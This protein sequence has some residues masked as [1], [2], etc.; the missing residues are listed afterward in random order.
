MFD[1]IVQENEHSFLDSDPS[2]F[3]FESLTESQ[4]PSRHR[5]LGLFDYDPYG[6][7]IFYCYKYGSMVE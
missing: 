2:D 3:P 4:P 7:D 1:S 6:I 5:I